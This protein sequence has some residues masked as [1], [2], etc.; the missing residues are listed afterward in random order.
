MRSVKPVLGMALALLLSGCLP[1]PTTVYVPKPTASTDIAQG[2]SKD[3]LFILRKN[4]NVGFSADARFVLQHAFVISIAFNKPNK[5]PK[6]FD[7]SKVMLIDKDT[8]KQYKP[9]N[10]YT[11]AEGSELD[12]YFPLEISKAPYITVKLPLQKFGVS[13]IELTKVKTVEVLQP[14]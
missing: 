6:D 5:I 9:T 11:F 2:Q 13:E 12:F 1:Y 10:I 7:V 4:L 8:G 14:F 3:Y